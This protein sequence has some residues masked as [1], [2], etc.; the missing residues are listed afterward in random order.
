MEGFAVQTS[1]PV[2][3]R[4]TILTIFVI[5]VEKSEVIEWPRGYVP[6]AGMKKRDAANRKNA[7]NA[8]SRWSL[9]RRRTPAAAAA[10]NLNNRN[11]EWAARFFRAAFF[12]NRFY[13][14]PLAYSR[15]FY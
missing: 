5:Y 10:G 7:P 11:S 14:K 9:R 13:E 4:L 15:A 2:S 8:T 12:R 6:T 3:S 1:R